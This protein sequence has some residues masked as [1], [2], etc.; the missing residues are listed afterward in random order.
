MIKASLHVR[1]K[2][3]KITRAYL[4]RSLY[5]YNFKTIICFKKKTSK[6]I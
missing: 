4:K 6:D 1:I 3:I 5:K 2:T